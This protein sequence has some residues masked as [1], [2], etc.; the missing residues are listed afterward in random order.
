MN[1]C[2]ISEDDSLSIVFVDICRFANYLAQIFSDYLAHYRS[3]RALAAPEKV[4]DGRNVPGPQ[5]LTP[6]LK[7][8]CQIIRTGVGQIK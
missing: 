2:T 6:D 5:L 3:W 8:L 7:P 4:S 1:C